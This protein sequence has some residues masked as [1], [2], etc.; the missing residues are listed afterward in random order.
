MQR[1][2]Y[3]IGVTSCFSFHGFFGGK[4]KEVQDRYEFP[5]LG[6]TQIPSSLS[7]VE[8]LGISAFMVFPVLAG[9]YAWVY[10]RARE[11]KM[12]SFKRAALC[13][14]AAMAIIMTFDSLSWLYRLRLYGTKRMYVLKDDQIQMVTRQHQP[15]QEIYWYRA[16]QFVVPTLFTVGGYL[17][18][19]CPYI[20]IPILTWKSFWHLWAVTHSVAVLDD[21]G[22][23]EKR[24]FQ[25]MQE[26]SGK[27][28]AFT[29]YCEHKHLEVTNEALR[30]Y[31]LQINS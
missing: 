4:V 29:K 24:V 6:K 10:F 25:E 14:T 15:Q 21:I 19:I 12:R 2:G 11:Q 9:T 8:S 7:S 22:A 13:S 5:K 17:T 18:G 3:V 23:G 16:N 27:E 26:R 31:E 28:Y 30:L 20:F 1:I